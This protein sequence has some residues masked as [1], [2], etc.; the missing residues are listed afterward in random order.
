MENQRVERMV[1]AL[2]WTKTT[3]GYGTWK[4]VAAT[5]YVE[6]TWN[7]WESADDLR[8]V[9]HFGDIEIAEVLVELCDKGEP[10]DIIDMATAVHL[11]IAAPWK[12][13]DIALTILEK[14]STDTTK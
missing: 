2:G 5:T 1:K 10:F 11:A 8:K 13:A 3:L 6:P 9:F 7:P 12:L 4:G 14:Q